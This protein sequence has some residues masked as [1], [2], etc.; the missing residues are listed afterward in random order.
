MEEKYLAAEEVLK[1]YGQE[2]LLSQYDKLS[3]EKKSQLL[4]DILT[5]DF[6]QIEELYKRINQKVDFTNSKIEPIGYTDKSTMSEKELKYY[7]DIGL[8]EIKSGKLAVVTMA[9]GQGTRL[10]H[11]GP[12]GTFDIGLDSHKPIFEILCDTLKEAQRKYGI[13]VVWYIMTSKE[14]NDATVNFFEQHNYFGYPKDKVIF[15]KQGELPMVDTNGKIL[16]GEDGLIKHAADGHVGIFLSMKK[17]GIIYDMKTRGIEWVFIGGVDNV[18]VNMVDPVLLGVTIDKKMLAAG[19]SVVKAG[20]HEKVGV[21]CKRN[22]KPSVV[23]YS[24]ISQEMAEATNKDGGLVYGESHILCNLFSVAAIEEIS[25][26]TLPYHSAFKKAK[27]LDKNGNLVT[28]DKPNAYKFEAFLFDA[29]ESLDDMAILR[30]KRE[31]EFA[32]VKNAEGVDSP[33]TARKLYKEFHKI[34]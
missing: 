22:G 15:F 13:F 23:E 17:N 4:D 19:K 16:I 5:L 26:N 34:K 10:G 27:Y 14:N 6:A 2:H 1:K 28:S 20:P 30:V 33:E 8:K 25:K 21:F 9:G 7:E 31:E 3:D 29:F 24:E 18:L 12:K 32:P 11:V